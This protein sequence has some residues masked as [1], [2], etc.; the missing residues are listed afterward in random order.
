[1]RIFYLFLISVMPILVYGQDNYMTL[2]I[3]TSE[4]RI[5]EQREMTLGLVTDAPLPIQE[6]WARAFID[7]TAYVGQDTQIVMATDHFEILDESNWTSNHDPGG[8]Y[9]SQ[10]TFKYTTW[11]DG[12]YL[13]YPFEIQLV[14]GQNTERLKTP[15]YSFICRTP[16]DTTIQG[17]AP[18]KDIVKTDFDFRPIKKSIFLFAL[19]KWFL[20]GWILTGIISLFEKKEQRQIRSMPI[21]LLAG[22]QYN[23]KQL[24]NNI[25][26][27]SQ[28]TIYSTLN[29]IIRTALESRHQIPAREMTSAMIENKLKQLK[30]S[31]DKIDDIILFFHRSDEVKYAKKEEQAEQIE[32]DVTLTK[33]LTEAYIDPSTMVRL[34]AEEIKQINPELY[35]QKRIESYHIASTSDRWKA[36]LIDS[37]VFLICALIIF[38]PFG[39]LGYA[40]Y[41]LGQLSGSDFALLAG[42][43]LLLYLYYY[44][45]SHAW[46]GRSIGKNYAATYLV[47]IDDNRLSISGALLRALVKLLGIIPLLVGIFWMYKSK[48]NQSWQD[49]IVKSFV[50]YKS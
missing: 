4:M 5:G 36:G 35:K 38:I 41:L 2:L 11:K 29:R 31:D 23:L 25:K 32:A 15:G 17:L 16:I 9:L 27:L 28:K 47:N 18:I 22:T 43:I 44:T 1:M 19:L 10:K 6:N 45:L 30:Y 49:I 20:L 50:V 48:N 24:E 12:Y 33:N 46:K 42:L 34:P 21:S 26:G 14:N 13:I 40:P 7:S 39:F 37:I 3:D 8:K